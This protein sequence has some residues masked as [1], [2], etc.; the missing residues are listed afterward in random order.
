[1]D[2]K[3]ALRLS[4]PLP[5]HFRV[6][7]KLLGSNIFHRERGQ[8]ERAEC[9]QTVPDQAVLPS[10]FHVASP[11]ILTDMLENLAIR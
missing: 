11:Q 2:G 5:P 10:S 4:Y 9:W 1:M 6:W 8:L 7:W 3:L